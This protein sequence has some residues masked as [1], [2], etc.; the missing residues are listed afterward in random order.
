MLSRHLC[1][2]R[3]GWAAG[4]LIGAFATALVLADEPRSTAP[5]PESATETVEILKARQAGDISVTVRG[6]GVDR[7][8]FQIKN[9][10]PRRLN[11]VI[12][13]GLVAAAS[14]GQAAGGAGGGG[15]QSMGLGTPTTNQG[16]F[17]RFL[18]NDPAQPGFQSIPP[19]PPA[20]QGVGVEP[21]KSV[22]FTVPSVCLNFGIPTPTPKDQFRLMD[23][24][25]YSPDPRV[26]K[27]LRTL[28]TIGTSQ[29]V[30]QAVMWHVANGMTFDQMAS[31]DVKP[32]N[33]FEL[34][35]A[36]RIVSAVDGSASSDIVDLANLTQARL[37]LSI[38]HEGQMAKV[39]HRLRSELQGR[40]VLG[41]PVQVLLDNEN[42]QPLP[43]TLHFHLSLRQAA[44]NQVEARLTARYVRYTGDW[45]L[46][47][48]AAGKLEGTVNDV[49]ADALAEAI[50]K[51]VASQFVTAR[52]ARRGPGTTTL[53][54]KNRLPLT[55]ANITF[56]TSKADNGTTVSVP[57]VGIGPGHAGLA[58]I[59]AAMGFVDRVELNGL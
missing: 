33:M 27:A 30:A 47:G 43:S 34:A 48:N 10:S 38:D 45:G 23:V 20:V 37:F 11:V 40:K 54:V 51:V 28:S 6:Q 9:T 49:K 26:R 14:A 59:S 57:A 44:K 5:G 24:N 35:T 4:L 15:F 55:I 46:I 8:K 1:R 58:P 29:G 39:A 56:R 18:R 36:A 32:F 25:D 16:S 3:A 2:V 17:G 22:D 50:D 52:I 19:V 13:P 42:V 12:P 7:V 31:Q 41:L 21:G 53:E